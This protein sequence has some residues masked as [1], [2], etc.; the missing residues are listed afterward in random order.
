MKKIAHVVLASL[1]VAALPACWHVAEEFVPADGGAADSDTDTDT[2]VDTDTDTDTD[3]D[4][5][6]G[7]DTGDDEYCFDLLFEV[8]YEPVNVLVLLDRSHSMYSSTMGDATYA[9]V[10]AAVLVDVVAENEETGLVNFGLAVF[11]SMSCPAGGGVGVPDECTPA[12]DAEPDPADDAPEVPIGGDNVDDIVAALEA[13]GQ[14]GGTPLCGSLGW[15]LSYLS[16]LPEE[17]AGY[18]TYVLAATD[19]APNCN[20]DADIATCEPSDGGGDVYFPEQCLD[21]ACSY[22]AAQALYAAGFELFLAGV[23]EGV[24]DFAEV[25]QGIAYYGAGGLLPPDEIPATPELWYSATDAASLQSAL[26]GIIGQTIDC[27]FTVPWEDIPA[28][29]P[30]PPWAPV[31][32]EC[33]KVDVWGVP[34]DMSPEIELVYSPDCSIE[35]AESPIFAWRWQGIDAPFED[36]YEFGL[37]ECTVIEPCPLACAMLGDGTWSGVRAGLGCLPPVDD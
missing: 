35:D 22:G 24:A 18:S 26:D 10:V 15:A 13:V 11:P 7:S 30:D 27:T 31:V 37:D 17:L 32:K 21:D 36:L 8:G 1:C 2:D 23:G 28:V 34:A 20:P 16:G 6:T 25:M 4:A 3:S 33:D 5:D 9:E 14:C 29:S 19:G 12:N